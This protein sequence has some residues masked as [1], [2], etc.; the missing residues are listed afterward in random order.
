MSSKHCKVSGLRK[1]FNPK[2]NA[3]CS[4]PR[5]VKLSRQVAEL[6]CFRDT[7][8]TLTNVDNVLNAAQMCSLQSLAHTAKIAVSSCRYE[9]VTYIHGFIFRQ[10]GHAG[11]WSAPQEI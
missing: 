6:R 7:G 3:E 4:I 11:L 5:S 8:W 1:Q 9:G 10:F 2:V